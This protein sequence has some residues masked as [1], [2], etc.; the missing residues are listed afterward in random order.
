MLDT[1]DNYL[2]FQVLIS[3]FSLSTYSKS[4]FNIVLAI[5]ESLS[6]EGSLPGIEELAEQAYTSV[7]A[8]S[9][10][11]KK[12]GFKDY[13]SLRYKFSN[14]GELV[15][16]K[17][18]YQYSDDPITVKEKILKNLNATWD[19]I[20]HA[21]LKE[22]VNILMNSNRNLFCGT[23][24]SMMCFWGVYKDLFFCDSTSYFL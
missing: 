15:N 19:N 3:E 6:N 13:Q 2:A 11:V 10:F 24:E 22:T 18:K 17:R 16:L 9:R 14:I 1:M 4:D 23:E 7:S 12:I 20:D 8:I 21:K 5:I